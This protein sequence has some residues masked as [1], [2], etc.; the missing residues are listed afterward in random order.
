MISKTSDTVHRYRT[1][2]AFLKE[3]YKERVYKLPL[4][5]PGTCPNRDPATGKGGCIYC[6]EEAAAFE[7]LDEKCDI[8]AQFEQNR[9]YIG[10]K[11]KAEKFIAYLQNHTATYMP[12]ENFEKILS[13]LAEHREDICAVYVSTRPDCVS[14]VYLDIL[15][16]IQKELGIDCVIELGLQSG[17]DDTLKILNRNHSIKD[18]EDAANIIHSYGFDICAH[19]I[20]D[21]P[22]DDLLD[23]ENTARII[24]NNHIQQVK[25]HSLYILKNTY[26]GDLYLKGEFVPVSYEEYLERMVLFI[27]MV[28]KQVIF[29]RFTGRAPK[30]RT[31]FCNFGKSWWRMQD[32][33]NRI[34]DEN[35]YFQG[36]FH[37]C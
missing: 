30:E 18:F 20:I 23:I 34:L 22:Y 13:T 25:C 37:T 1:F 32:D 5:Y 24:N 28:N 17:N 2:S 35:N 11:Y 33:I 10:T 16:D 29:Q 3:R 36:D 14:R 4:N 15:K 26:L 6:G 12:P 19:L 8:A 21:L 9:E 27:R 31:L 7:L